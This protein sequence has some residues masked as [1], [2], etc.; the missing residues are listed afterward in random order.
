M[1]PYNDGQGVA[2][3]STSPSQVFLLSKEVGDS[4]DAVNQK[5]HIAI[6]ETHVPAYA[7]HL[8]CQKIELHPR[9]HQLFLGGR[10]RGVRR[11][12]HGLSY[13]TGQ[14]LLQVLRI[15]RTLT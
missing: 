10:R 12:S 11:L 6:F 9:T 7:T 13:L 2:R 3:W 1:F 14:Q 5:Q 8:S 4:G 15:R